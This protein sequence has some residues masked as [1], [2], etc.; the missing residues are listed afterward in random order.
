VNPESI[1]FTARNV[2]CF[3]VALL[4]FCLASAGHAQLPP[5]PTTFCRAVL[6]KQSVTLHG[7]MLIDSFNSM[8]PNHSTNGQYDPAKRADGGDVASA[9]SGVN[10]ITDT[11]NT[12]IYG[13]LFTS[14][15]GTVSISGN[16]SI[17]SLAWVNGGNS[18]IQPGWYSNNLQAAIPDATLPG[19][20]FTTFQQRSGNV[21]GTNYNY[22]VTN[23]NYKAASLSFSGNMCINGRVVLYLTNG[24]SITGQ[25][26]LYIAPGASL[27]LY[28]GGQTSISG[29]GT[30]NGTGF[31]TNC[32]FIGLPSCT[33]IQS[34]GG[35]QFIGTIYAPQ[36]AVTL[37]GGGGQT[38]NFAGALVANT[39]SISGNYQFHF[40]QSLCGGCLPPVILTP[41]ANQGACP[42]DSVTF[43]VGAT[44]LSLTY[45]WYKGGALLIG[46]THST[47]LVTN[48]TAASAGTYSV[49]V[50][51]V[52]GSAVTNSATLT[53]N[54]QTLI[55]HSPTDQTICAG[56]NA[57][58]GVDATGTALSYQWYKGTSLL[59]GATTSSLIISNAQSGDAGIYSVVV[60][61]QCGLPQTN[62]AM[63]TV[64]S[65]V[66][67]V[68][69][70]VG[71]S[72]CLGDT[73]HFSVEAT[74][75]SLT[76]QW[77]K[78]NSLLGG[79][80]T[81]SLMI[82]NAQTTDAAIYS[83]V[84]SG[85]CGQPKT[86]SATLTVNNPVLVV[87]P[88][89]DQTV[90]PGDTSRFTVDV[91]GTALTYQWFKAA[92]V[93]AGATT[94]SLSIS[95][96]QSGDG[97]IYSVVVSGACGL[98]QS[99]SATLTVNS[100]IAVV[101]P[102]ADQSVCVGDAAHFS[103]DATGTGLTYQWYEATSLLGGATTS[104]LVISN[105]QTND[106][107]IYSVVISGAC[108][109]PHTNSAILTVNSPIVLVHSPAD[110]TVC[111][112]GNA[113][114]AIDATGTA[115]S[116]QWYKA[117]A[118]LAGATT[119]TL[120]LT[121][122]QSAD[123]GIYSV[124]VTGTCGLPQTNSA[125]LTVS[126]NV[127]ITMG[128]S[129]Q[130]VCQ[131]SSANFSVTAL[132]AGLTF[133]WYRGNSLIAGQIAPDL[134]LTNVQSSD[135][136]LYMVVVSGHCG[137]P[138]TNSA[139]LTVNSPVVVIHR[140]TDQ[141]VCPDDTAHFAID[142]TG[143]ALSY[144]WYKAAAPVA[145]AT[146]S[147]LDITNAQS[148][149]AGIYSVVVSGTCGLAQSNSATL[150]VNSPVLVVHPPTDQSVCPGDTAHFSVDATGTAL[151]YQWFKA[152]TLL[153]GATTS[154]LSITNVQSTNAA[155]YSVVVSGACGL[156]QSNSATLTLN[157]PV[158]VAHR[159]TDQTVCAGDTAHFSIDATGSSLSYQWYKAATLLAGA[160]NSS[161]TISNAQS[162]DAGGYSVVVSGACGQPQTNSAILTVNSP[163]LVIHPPTDQNVCPGD[164][165]HF[166]VDATGTALTYQ[167]FKATTPLNGATTSSLTI[168]NAQS[169]NAAIYSVV[170]SGTCG[171]PR[172]NSATLTVN[173]PAL[174]VHPP[175]DQSVCPG[176]TAHFSVEATGTALTY[177]WFKATTLLTGATASGLNITNAQSADAGSYS[178]IVSGTCG[179][180]RTNSATLTVNSPVLI[181]HPPTDQ[182]VC[183][184][185]AGHFAVDA[186]GTGLTY[187]WYRAAATL[188][189]ATTTSLT[190]SNA[191]ST[192]A[193]IYSV[194]VTGTCGQPQTN[195]ATLS[196]SS[197]LLVVHPPTDQTVC[198]GDNAQ[199]TVDAT[200][201]DLAYQWFKAATLLVG[202]S[203]SSLTV[204][205]AQSTDAGI[206]SV[207][208]SGACSL[209]QTNSAT[210]TVSSNV[211]ISTGPSD[212]T[213]CQGSPAIFTVAAS[214]GSLTYQWYHANTLLI[215]QT[216]PGLVLTN[217]QPSDGGVYTVVVSG[218]CG[219]PQ[220]NGAT[221]TV[222]R[223]V[224]LTPL[225]SVIRNLG[226]SVT[227]S[228][229]ASG[230]G[231]FTFAWLRNGSLLAGRTNN[232]V[233]FTNLG[234]AD[235]GTYTAR[236]TGECNTVE[237]SATLAINHPPTVTIISP[238]NGSVFIAP[239]NFTVLADAQDID[240]YVTNVD[241]FS[242]G[243]NRLG[244][245]TNAPYFVELTNVAA[246]TYTFTAR[247][248][249]D[250]GATGVAAPVTVTVMPR[251]PL[252][253]LSAMQFDPQ[254]GLFEQTV[255]VSNPT[256]STFDAVRVYVGNL[257]N[258][259]VL[260]N[261]TGTTNGMSYVES[262]NGVA[263]GGHVDFVLEYYVPSRLQPNPT[264]TP[265]L[266]PPAQ[267]GG[268]SVSG[269]QQ[270]I[271]RIIVLPNLNILVEFSTLTN[272]LYYIQYTSDMRSWRTAVPAVRGNGTR[273]Q[274]IDAGPPKT[275]SPPTTV[276]SRSYRLI[277]LP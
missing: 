65:P 148:T 102:P 111:P 93:L 32:V 261:A 204:T 180:P 103:V 114:F 274:W 5:S 152:A 77:Y 1:S 120:T 215:D 216:E 236:V 268:V 54:S 10:V 143:T 87:H 192:D 169:T 104:S 272:R 252:T 129:D 124:V 213:V 263:P 43:A 198:P 258:H 47:L 20:T 197:P 50:R 231:R 173:S 60:G 227:F 121:N 166:T 133:Q 209:G 132:G 14:P 59:A 265:V 233:T 179:Q 276:P 48:V 92:T 191:Q 84:V 237:V 260:W 12:S 73:A 30:I 21:S 189:G 53:V 240:G 235:A 55:L 205:N 184:G 58:F 150:T 85:I 267:G 66:L 144:Q 13:H 139:T 243:T 257:T 112:G 232:S 222:N 17:G 203:T 249:D 96:A 130:T 118:L 208:V 106:A 37:S 31:A 251:A 117:A 256:Y 275:D 128:P 190:V 123:A 244:S 76:Y 245:S 220:T 113:H 79:A 239:A 6:A 196:V 254:T 119:N 105:V 39:I 199:F 273:I 109:Q 136:G 2:G 151:T 157:S 100:A 200:G 8:D 210:L 149:D 188:A 160:T 138:Q 29:Q 207:V 38:V 175:A 127:V 154:G 241:F 67:V 217:V 250:L 174:V 11:G 23:G 187:Q 34:S 246:G 167:W 156:T 228:T 262:Y 52:C 72:V 57:S 264:L 35:S 230:S 168:T 28:L 15:S 51:T 80:T 266:V 193:G 255:R 158:L 70:P 94:S 212:Q 25:G 171:Q 147:S 81:S 131:G 41:P 42:G 68:H 142:A 98:A 225:I 44:G 229:L 36:A 115:L 186:T 164:T 108:G 3:A 9:A 219:T 259:A 214:G 62:S 69:S 125:T 126:S 27:T 224:T 22:V 91:S 161:L 101:H 83:V 183:A 194:V 172:T 46:Q 181:V 64:N 270:H 170:V 78:A 201:T 202:A 178:V 155:I 75:T 18:G 24:L 176:D 185:D 141:R 74:G 140:P 107:A 238:T 223:T 89:S 182:T 226:D 90:C 165:A 88:P 86:N 221:L 56:G 218:H 40:D 137:A 33:G 206:Y 99:N 71:Q 242:F 122:A 163:V 195:S 253:I 162:T 82:T 95:N 45:Q 269:F 211:V 135:A 49:A 110:Q 234:Y 97:G 134:L 63:L 146:N 116:Y 177:Q 271:D 248:F 26:Y 7:T 145:G 153:A 19:V 16:A 277:L 247:A 61:G 4:T 159:P